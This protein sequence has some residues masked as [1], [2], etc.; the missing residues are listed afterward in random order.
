MRLLIRLFIVRLL[1]IVVLVIIGGLLV[2]VVGG[3]V[4]L[5][6][7]GVGSGIGGM[8]ILGILG[9]LVLIGGFLGILGLGLGFWVGFLVGF[10][11]GGRVCVEVMVLNFVEVFLLL[12]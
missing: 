11:G 8:E 12:M 2:V 1:M 10:L 4:L 5:D 7:I 6:G 9:F 3:I